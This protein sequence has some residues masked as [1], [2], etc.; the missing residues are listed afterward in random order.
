M[1]TPFTIVKA[2]YNKYKNQWRWMYKA[3]ST[4][5]DISPDGK[6]KYQ[7]NRKFIRMDLPEVQNWNKTYDEEN[8]MDIKLTKKQQKE[9]DLI[10]QRIK[11]REMQLIVDLSNGIMLI[12]QKKKVMEF[13]SEWLHEYALTKNAK[14]TVNMY[15]RIADL[16]AHNGNPRFAELN[17]IWINNFHKAQHVRVKEGQIAQGT[18]RAYYEKLK[19][20]MYE[21]E[22]DG[23]LEGVTSMYS[24]VSKVDKG[25]SKVGDYFTID[26]LKILDQAEWKQPILKRAFLFMCWTGLRLKEAYSLTWNDVK[27][28]DGRTKLKI[29]QRK[30]KIGEVIDLNQKAVGYMGT[31]GAKND[32]VFLG[33]SQHHVNENLTMWANLAG[34]DREVKSHDGRRTCAY[35]VWTKTSKLNYVQHYLSHQNLKTTEDYMKKHFGRLVLETKAEDLFPTF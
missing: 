35:L 23:K 29:Q 12:D 27:E 9:N 34:I 1:S 11:L 30:N 6:R 13:V 33:L 25:S 4:L 26:E 7:H 21:A 3:P 5:V 14:N 16:I 10:V 24:K 8:K 31:R 20:A 28:V 18:A 15:K 19:F 17:S 2:D 32:K 22:R